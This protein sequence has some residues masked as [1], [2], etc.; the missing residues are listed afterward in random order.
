MDSPSTNSRE[1][2]AGGR[3]KI[4]IIEDNPGDTAL[5]R[6]L[7]VDAHHDLDDARNLREGLAKLRAAPYD[8]ILL[9]L[10]LPDASPFA[11]V[12][13]TLSAR[14]NAALVALTGLDDDDLAYACLEAGVNEFVRKSGMTAGVLLGAIDHALARMRA[15]EIGHRLEVA[16]RHAALGAIASFASHELRNL[17]MVI[18]S[19]LEVSRARL[20]LL[21][22]EANRDIIGG[23]YRALD[24]QAN[25]I[26][27]IA[28][29]VAQ[30][31]AFSDRERADSAPLTDVPAAIDRS[32][33]VLNR[34][35]RDRATVTVDSTQ[36][37]PAGIDERRLGQVLLN[38]LQNAIDAIPPG[39]PSAH[40][41][42]LRTRER[43][44]HV[45]VQVSDTGAG[46]TDDV[47]AHLFEPFFTSKPGGTGLGLA[48]SA[49]L[50]SAF[51]GTITC[52][53]EPGTGTTFTLTL[54]AVAMPA[55]SKP[56]R[57]A[58]HVAPPARPRVLVIDDNA[59]LLQRLV[60]LL[61]L[62]YDVVAAEGGN[63]ALTL[64]ENDRAFDAIL[65]D[66]MM[67]DVDGIDVC[68]ALQERSPELL[69]RVALL[70]GGTFTQRASKFVNAGGIY[71]V[72]KPCGRAELRHAVAELASR[73]APG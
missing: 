30:L 56:V 38:L 20:D 12:D 51:G 62:D 42:T 40:R 71:V 54:P 70:T 68:I 19:T 7:L 57:A 72:R 15:A 23:I 45:V 29:I 10:R 63:A 31:E 22:G 6:R 47:R 26:G 32:L 49:E 39:D 25:A 5:V 33:R 21:D 27:Q 28:P 41:I 43:D 11:A 69:S 35:L 16:E 1:R 2:A 18:M 53:S 37:S 50:I 67:P 3:R 61:A 9:D 66:V 34:Q 4:L 13:M 14:G 58:A 60:E 17:A 55:P 8:V 64:L 48:V 65:C 46:I 73:P 52:D 36:C 59:A 44:G 24:E